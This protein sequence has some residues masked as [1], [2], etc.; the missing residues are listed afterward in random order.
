MQGDCCPRWPAPCHSTQAIAAGAVCESV[1]PTC[2]GAQ[3]NCPAGMELGWGCNTLPDLSNGVVILA[4][5]QISPYTIALDSTSVYWTNWTYN[6]Y[7]GTVMKVPI[8]GGNTVTLAA[9]LGNA[10]GIAVDGSGV[11]FAG[12]M[13]DDSGASL[14]KVGLDGGTARRLA[15]AFMNDPFAVGPSGVYGTGGDGGGLTIVTVPLEGGTAMPLVPSSALVQTAS[16]YGIAVD[17]HNVYW[18]FFGDP[19]T[20][21]KAPLGGGV[22]V[23]LATTAGPGYGIAVDATHV[24]FGTGA[25]VM[26]VPIDG[27]TLATLADSTGQGIALDDSYLYFTD[28]QSSVKKVSKSG[29]AVITLAAGQT[30]PLGIAV[31]ANSVYWGNSGTDGNSDGSVM[32]LT[33][34]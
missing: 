18:T 32:R 14:F 8:G 23:T 24:Y 4:S 17:A 21:R 11:Y 13:Q 20:V 3:W 1:L 7:E 2:E 5:G 9:G 25:A 26:K 28:W 15:A 10:N 34:K 16:S 30:R 12:A 6:G 33:P 29:G 27:G 19:T 22:P 31:D